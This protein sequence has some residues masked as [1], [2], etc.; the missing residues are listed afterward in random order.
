MDHSR[1]IYVWIANSNH[2]FVVAVENNGNGTLTA[3]YTSSFPGTYLIYIED[4]DIRMPDKERYNRGRPI[5]GSPFSLEIAGEQTLDIDAL[6]VCGSVEEDIESSF[7][8]PGSWV[9]SNIASARHGVL[10]DGWVFQPETCVHD[11]FTYDDLMLLAS[12]DEPTWLLALGN[13][14]LRGVF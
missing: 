12:L 9:S 1:F 14:V 10:R 5:V 4:V 11:T 3:S 7:W 6:P 8:R 13:S 2:T